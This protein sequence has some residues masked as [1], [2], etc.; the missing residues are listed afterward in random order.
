[1]AAV[2]FLS[3]RIS[4]KSY[5]TWTICSA[6]SCLS[7]DRNKFF[8]YSQEDRQT[9][10]KLDRK[11]LLCLFENI[12][13]HRMKTPINSRKTNLFIFLI[14]NS[15]FFLH[16]P[17]QLISN[18]YCN[19]MHIF[20]ERGKVNFVF[21]L[22]KNLLEIFWKYIKIRMALLFCIKS[23]PYHSPFLPKELINHKSLTIIWTDS[24]G[25]CL[26]DYFV[27]WSIDWWKRETS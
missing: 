10:R 12:S 6:L 9:E 22:R 7:I 13:Q 25:R 2:T 15:P 11:K 5:I 19:Y 26:I 23:V 21:N 27:G 3:L 18:S 14:L 24:T 8:I 4:P 17:H 16:S 1:M 20:F